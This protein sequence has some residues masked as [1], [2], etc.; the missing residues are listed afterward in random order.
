VCG[1]EAFAAYDVYGRHFKSLRKGGGKDTGWPG[2]GVLGSGLLAVRPGERGLGRI[3]IAWTLTGISATCP[4]FPCHICSN[5][6]AMKEKYPSSFRTVLLHLIALPLVL[7]STNAMAQ[8]GECVEAL[9]EACPPATSFGS[10][11]STASDAFVAAVPNTNAGRFNLFA[12][13]QGQTYE[14]SMCPSDGATIPTGSSDTQLT[15]RNGQNEH[16]C[17]S[18]DIC[19]FHA[20]ILWTATYSGEA[21]VQVN[22]YDCVANNLNYGMVWRCI[23][24]GS[25]G[26]DEHSMRMT[27]SSWPN[28]AEDVLSIAFGDER[29]G[30]VEYAVFDALGRQVL[31]GV[32]INTGDN[33][34]QLDI[35]S[36]A[37]GHYVLRGAN[38]DLH[39][40]QFFVKQ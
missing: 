25:I 6:Q 3:V 1:T 33:F 30:R 18:D 4:M 7:M 21:R 39:G 13:I 24:C 16:I 15:L 36:L 28:P 32:V 34:H 14:W 2:N 11:Q 38:G 26:M 35:S 22:E 27:I 17:N 19:G 9:G 12:V 31:Q 10:M 5:E 29:T 40:S 8:A 37:V 23:T 20:K